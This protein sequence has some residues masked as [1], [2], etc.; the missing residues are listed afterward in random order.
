MPIR[1]LPTSGLGRAPTRVAFVYAVFGLL[2]IFLSDGLL[3]WLEYTDD[4]AFLVSSVKGAAFVLVTAVLLLWLVRREVAALQQSENLLRAVVEG[5][6]DAVYVKD[7]DGRHLMVNKAAAGFVGRPVADVI[8]RSAHELFEA[9]DADRLNALD[10]A[11]MEGGAVVTLEETLTADGV[12]RTYLATKAPYRDAR[13]E[14]IGLI[15]VSRDITERNRMEV[16]IRESEQRWRQLA[17]AIPQIVWT[18]APDGGLTHLN[19]QAGEYSG[20]G[21]EAILG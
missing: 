2:W 19:A 6:M 4:V 20:L 18:A 13:G 9:A 8:G 11:V 15:G 12:S 3:A 14:V 10:R 5:T 1:F 7:R 21:P 17:D 16:A